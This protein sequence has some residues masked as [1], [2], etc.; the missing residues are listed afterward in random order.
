MIIRNYASRTK[1]PRLRSAS[2]FKFMMG[3]EENAAAPHFPPLHTKY[4]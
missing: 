4:I 2:E 3:E 1:W